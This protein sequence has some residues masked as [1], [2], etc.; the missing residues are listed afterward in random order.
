MSRPFRFGVGFPALGVSYTGWTDRLRRIE[1]QGYSVASL[2]DHPG[3]DADGPFAALAAAAMVTSTLRVGTRLLANDFRHPTIVAREMA[4]IDQLSNGRLE[5]GLGAGWLETDYAASGMDFDS[6]R[7]RIQR[8]E[9]ALEVLKLLFSGRPVSYRGAHYRVGQQTGYPPVVQRPHPPLVVG[10]GGRR[11]LGV[12]ARLADVVALNDDL[13][14]GSKFLASPTLETATYE[15]TLA[16]IEVVKE[17]AG[18][19]FTTLEIAQRIQYVRVTR[20][21]WAAAA[22][23]ATSVG[24]DPRTVLRSPAILIGDID[25]IAARLRE[26]RTA[27]GISYLMLG[28]KDAEAFAPIIPLLQAS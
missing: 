14:S 19:R 13:R 24:S 8:L 16:K 10:G 15:S 3:L 27:T 12:A 20:D 25:A 7:V 9:E 5:V 11:V 26:I 1:E 22:A 6:A 28:V 18:D 4:T 2:A 21:P 17:A 23:I